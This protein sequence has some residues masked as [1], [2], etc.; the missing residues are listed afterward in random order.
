MKQP[1]G[2]ERRRKLREQG[3]P[4]YSATEISSRQEYTRHRNNKRRE[5]IDAFKLQKGCAD[6]GY[7]VHPAALEFDHLPEFGPR[8]ITVAKLKSPF[9]PMANIMAEI[10]KCE[11]VCANCH[12]IRTDRRRK[13]AI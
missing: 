12:N 1:P 5:W 11:V 3:L 4:Q 7:K 2:S 9:T 8:Q 10:A 6:C 13:G